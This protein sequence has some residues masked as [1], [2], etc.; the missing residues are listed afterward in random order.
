MPIG[1]IAVRL[2]ELVLKMDMCSDS[3]VVSA[4]FNV[5][6]LVMRDPS[7]LYNLVVPVL[8][9]KTGRARYVS[10]SV[11]VSVC[12]YVYACEGSRANI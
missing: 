11:S 6:S 5:A 7:A 9:P 4:L 1:A 12:V 8:L 3:T 2:A 10:V